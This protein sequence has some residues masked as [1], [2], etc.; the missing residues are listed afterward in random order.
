MRNA[1][2]AFSLVALAATNALAETQNTQV[3]KVG[4]DLE[5]PVLAG[6]CLEVI[7]LGPFGVG[8]GRNWVCEQRKAGYV[9]S[10]LDMEVFKAL[11]QKYGIKPKE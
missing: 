7:D 8:I 2:F 4:P 1:I 11:L 3:A 6:A 5:A 9:D 10:N